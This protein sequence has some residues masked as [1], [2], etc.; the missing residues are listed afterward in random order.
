MEIGMKGLSRSTT[1]S[2]ELFPWWVKRRTLKV[3]MRCSAVDAIA[4]ERPQAIDSIR[5]C[6]RRD[7]VQFPSSFGRAARALGDT[8]LIENK[9]P[10]TDA[11]RAAQVLGSPLR[12]LH[13]L[14]ADP[15][16]LATMSHI[17]PTSKC[18]L[19]GLSYSSTEE[20]LRNYFQTFGE[21]RAV[22]TPT[23]VPCC[24]R[25]CARVPSNALLKDQ[26]PPSPLLPCRS[27]MCMW[28][29]TA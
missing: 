4:E 24:R 1:A 7:R 6:H 19:G 29:V 8:R 27:R 18:F 10:V 9:R 21:V 2:T 22:L 23:L 16:A 26:R 14:R 5:R 25:G 17:D 28:C 20:S 12:L 11:P 13:V 15:V 3:T